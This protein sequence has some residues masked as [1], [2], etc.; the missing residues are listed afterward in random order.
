MPE[1]PAAPVNGAELLARIR[2]VFREETTETC[3]RPDLL[4]EWEKLNEELGGLVAEQSA[5]NRKMGTGHTPNVRKVAKAIEVLETQIQE[6]SMK[7]RFRAM[8]KDAWQEL[9]ALHPPRQGNDVDAFSGY[10]RDAVFDAAIR[11][12]LI[13]PVFDEASF[14][15]LERVCNPSEWEELRATV[16]SV[17]RAGGPAPKSELAGR[18]LSRPA[19]GRQSLASGE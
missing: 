7:C 14:A 17:N 9:I 3:L 6:A 4:D 13:D 15:E 11:K 12:C 19:R 8:S 10:D 5:G 2:P 1:T 16:R 18:I